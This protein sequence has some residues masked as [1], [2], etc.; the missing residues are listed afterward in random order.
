MEET[1]PTLLA[2]L[3]ALVEPTASGDSMSPLRW[4]SK[5]VRRVATELEEQDHQASYHVVGELLRHVGY[6]LQANQKTREGASH[7]G[8]RGARRA[9]RKSCGST[10]L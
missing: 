3:D 8:R 9:I 4:T 2:A 5:S 7:A 10:I 1:D 6:S